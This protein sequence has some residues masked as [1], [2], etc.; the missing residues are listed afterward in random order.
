[1]DKKEKYFIQTMGCQMNVYDSE[2]LA[3]Y[4]ENMGISATDNEADADI[5]ILNTCAVRQKAEE[6]VF[7]KLGMWQKLKRS[8]PEKIMILWGC[9]VQQP[10]KAGHLSKRYSFLDL[11]GGPHALG[12]FPE[13]LEE[14]RI[15]RTP[16]L[17]LEEE[18]RRGKD[19]PIKRKH[20]AFAW[21]PISYGCDNYCTYCI[22]PYVR[23]R[24]KSR[25]PDEIILEVKE[26]AAQGCRE[27]TLLGQNVNSYGRDLQEKVDFADLLQM[28]ASI[29]GILRIRYMT[30]HPRD[31][32]EKMVKTIK[33]EPKICE[34]F[35]LPL[36]AGSNRILSLMNRGYTRE[37]YLNLIEK[38]RELIPHAAITTDIIVGFPGEREEDFKLTMD[39]LEKVRF[40]AAF[41]F[42]YSTREGTKAA[43]LP[44]Q[45]PDTAKRERIVILNNRQAEI[46]QEI[47]RKLLGSKQELLVEGKSKTNAANYTG[48]TRT[49]KLVHFPTEDKLSEGTMVTVEITETGAWTLRGK[50]ISANTV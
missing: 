23:G 39:M 49:N 1:M 20:A 7:S 40:D 21:V 26:L 22:V 27:I 47:N 35:H 44:D 50:Y 19:F 37:G 16:V 5:L 2:V 46:A 3:G 17:A 45:V 29:T 4:L 14:A 13:L 12:K 11:I 34:H 28:V 31:F 38:I 42:V 24:E 25:L 33:R 9:V 10:G 18:E 15:S 43:T 41:T 48:R 30:S 32:T 36:Q 6:K 8:N